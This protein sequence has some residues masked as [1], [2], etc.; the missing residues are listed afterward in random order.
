M[1][2]GKN[3]AHGNGRSLELTLIRESPG[4]ERR[5]IIP[6]REGNFRLAV[7]FEL[8]LGWLNAVEAD[9]AVPQIPNVETAG[10]ICISSS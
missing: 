1:D 7:L 4:E 9:A 2:D 10:K 8:F 5:L 6:L 3:R